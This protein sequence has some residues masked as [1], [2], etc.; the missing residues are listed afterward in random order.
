MKL[1]SYKI[2]HRVDSDPARVE[3]GPGER[4]TERG[5]ETVRHIHTHIEGGGGGRRVEVGVPPGSVV[6]AIHHR[7]DPRHQRPQLRLSKR[8][9]LYRNTLPAR[10]QPPEVNYGRIQGKS[11]FSKRGK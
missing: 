3:V 7:V 11:P 9:I 6:G 2:D 8:G 1:F 4:T 10:H 5:R